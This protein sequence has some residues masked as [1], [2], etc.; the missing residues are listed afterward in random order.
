METPRKPPARW[1]AVTVV[2]QTSSCAAAALCRNTRFLSKDAPRLPLAG[3]EHPEECNCKFR[4]F[5]DRRGNGGRRAVDV[6]VGSGGEKP[7]RERRETRG[8]RAR[9]KR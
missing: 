5:D 1:H 2:L 7:A 3:C 8:R 6:G 4:H 9:D